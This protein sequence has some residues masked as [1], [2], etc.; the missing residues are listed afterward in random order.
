MTALPSTEPLS[1]CHSRRGAKLR[2]AAPEGPKLVTGAAFPVKRFSLLHSVPVD[3]HF[4]YLTEAAALSVA[5][6][7]QALMLGT[8]AV[9]LLKGFEQ[10]AVGFNVTQLQFVSQIRQLCLQVGLPWSQHDHSHCPP[11]AVS[12]KATTM[13]HNAPTQGCLCHIFSNTNACVCATDMHTR[14]AVPP[15]VGLTHCGPH[16][17]TTQAAC[18]RQARQQQ[19]TLLTQQQR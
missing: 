4:G 3:D 9:V 10:L 6:A 17:T 12:L 8:L 1:S 18:R 11:R 2:G 13:L 19:T 14:S 15:A 5:D 16:K 7:L